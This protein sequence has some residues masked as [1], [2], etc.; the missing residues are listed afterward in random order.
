VAEHVEKCPRCVQVLSARDDYI[1]PLVAA[2]H[3]PVPPDLFPTMPEKPRLVAAG[4]NGGAPGSA[5]QDQAESWTPPERLGDY[6][7]RGKLGSGAMGMVYLAMHTRL[8]KQVA[9]K[10]LPPDRLSQP[11]VVARFQREMEVVGRLEHPHLVRALDAREESGMYLLA[12]E[13]IEG[14]DLSRLTDRS[15]PLP[16]AD[17]CEVIRQAALG[18]QY[19]HEQCRLVHRDLKP[20]NLMV[21]YGGCVK[22]LD[23]GLA[24]VVREHQDSGERA[25]GSLTSEHGVMGTVDYMAPEQWENSHTVDI[26]ADLYSLGC[27]LYYLLTGGPPFGGPEYNSR[28][29]KMQAHAHAPV[30]PV[31]ANRPD[32]PDALAAVLERL[33]A[34]QSDARFATPAEVIAAL[35]PFTKGADLPKLISGTGTPPVSPVESAAPN[36]APPVKPRQPRPNHKIITPRRLVIGILAA[37]TLGLAVVTAGKWMSGTPQPAVLKQMTLY[38]R[39][40]NDQEV[41]FKKLIT[42]SREQDPEPIQPPLGPKDDFQLVGAFDRPTFWY[43]LW[44]DTRGRVTVAAKSDRPQAEVEYPIGEMVSVDEADPAGV[45]VLVLAAGTVPAEEGAALLERRLQGVGQPPR[46]LPQRWAVQLRGPGGTRPA[47]SN[48][49]LSKYLQAIEDRMPPGLEMVHML[50]LQTTK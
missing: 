31:R 15:G 7:I 16:V 32:V 33:L 26:R 17:A 46:Q 27:T 50:F 29:K 3:M 25:P 13:Y 5:D 49:H 11:K 47:P 9:V 42:D 38:V 6:H 36:V 28:A 22:V 44:F 14:S 23:L 19:A 41:Y 12:M 48:L 37:V 4:A 40:G 45:H 21:T 24:R 34:K 39:R 30:P 20:S 35:E 43:L 8:G 18:L 1:D 10:I 2:L